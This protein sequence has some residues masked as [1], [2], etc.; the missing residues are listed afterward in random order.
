MTHSLLD[1]KRQFRAAL[2]LVGLTVEQWALAHDY[3]RHHVIQVIEGHRVSRT[4]GQT[5]DAFIAE[6]RAAWCEAA[7]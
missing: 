2:A 3:S 7:A 6:S 4:L 1:R 5:I